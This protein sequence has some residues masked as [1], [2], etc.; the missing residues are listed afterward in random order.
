M[1]LFPCQT[2]IILR[3]LFVVLACFAFSLSLNMATYAASFTARAT[4]QA[5]WVQFGYDASHSRFNRHETILK[6]GNVSKLVLDWKTPTGGSIYSSTAVVNNIVYVGSD[7]DKVYAFNAL[8]GVLL[9]ST[10]TNGKI[11]SSP[12]V[13]NGIVYVGS[14]DDKVY[15]FNASTG[16]LL[17]SY[18]TNFGTSSSPAVAN[19]IVY[20]GSGDHYVYALNATTGTLVWSTLIIG[21]SVNTSPTVANEI[22]YVSAC[23]NLGQNDM[24][25]ALNARTG[26]ILWTGMA[27]NNTDGFGSSPAVVNGVVYIGSGDDNLYAFHLPS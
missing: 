4:T 2:R 24:L 8:T 20:I 23:D 10:A 18:A 15:A 16:A 22:V 13:A 7:D 11:F 14:Y 21:C 26:T 12:A 3:A 27:G 17:W 1:G 25:Y 6:P 5:N 19:G 9:W